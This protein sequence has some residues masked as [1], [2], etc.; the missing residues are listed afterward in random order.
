VS[1]RQTFLKESGNLFDTKDTWRG[2]KE[3]L[4]MVEV[5]NRRLRPTF[6]QRKPATIA[7]IK[8]KIF[9]MPF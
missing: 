3:Y 5:R 6:S 2:L 4:P 8:L 7:M 9:K 1:K